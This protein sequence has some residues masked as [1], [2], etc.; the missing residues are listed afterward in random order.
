MSET[1]LVSHPA[2]VL[3]VPKGGRN[4]RTS[5][6]RMAT[7]AFLPRLS[8]DAFEPM[9]NADGGVMR[10]VIR[11]SRVWVPL[12]AN[13]P[14]GR[15]PVS[16]DAFGAWLRGDAAPEGD[17]VTGYLDGVF[18]RTPLVAVASVEDR[19]GRIVRAHER[20]MP[21]DVDR[22]RSIAHDGRAAAAAA[23][24]VLLSQ[25]VAVVGD[26]V[27]LRTRPLARYE[28]DC[29]IHTLSLMIHHPVTVGATF[30][31]A[32]DALEEGV[33]SF[34]NAWEP[35]PRRTP[36]LERFLSALPPGYARNDDA[37]HL[38][39]VLPERILE[40]MRP[41]PFQAGDAPDPDVLAPGLR[42]LSLAAA[43]GGIGEGEALDA[44]ATM[45]AATDRL[46][47]TR[48]SQ[49][50]GW[51]LAKI[52]DHLGGVVLPRLRSAAD[53]DGADLALLAR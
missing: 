48:G 18:R 40:A 39:N 51:L 4:E 44:L 7:P 23:L 36:P 10:T 22:S 12:G 16:P 27:M 38:A 50:D 20:G 43:T 1:I 45:H 3:H 37:H 25:E 5:F 30:P 21:V 52:R 13:T 32:L 14:D 2:A 6:A 31:I 19:T 34:R 53:I 28:H 9:V 15:I 47:G 49:R 29:T 11:E 35:K 33:E 24:S 8:R 17:V 46:L 41:A 26:H 42:R